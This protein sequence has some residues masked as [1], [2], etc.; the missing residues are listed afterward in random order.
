M[1]AAINATKSPLVI[2][3]LKYSV[4]LIRDEQDLPVSGAYEIRFLAKT[5]NL[6]Y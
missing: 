3:P 6:M 4:D 5:Y 2:R 1:S